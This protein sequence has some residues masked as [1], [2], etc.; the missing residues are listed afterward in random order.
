MSGPREVT[1]ADRQTAKVSLALSA[2]SQVWEKIWKVTNERYRQ[3]IE[4]PPKYVGFL[5]ARYD[6]T[7]QWLK[8]WDVMTFHDF[9]GNALGLDGPLK[10]GTVEKSVW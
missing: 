2:L 7:A 10:K 3:K 1:P 5:W 4:S 8:I 9:T 6:P